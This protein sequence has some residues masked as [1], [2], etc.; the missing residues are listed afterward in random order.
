MVDRAG[1]RG[2]RS[3]FRADRNTRGG[4]QLS[5]EI[6]DLAQFQIPLF[7][8]RC[9]GIAERQ[10]PNT[11]DISQPFQNK[12]ALLCRQFQGQGVTHDCGQ[13]REGKVVEWA[14][15]FLEASR[16]TPPRA[17]VERFAIV[18]NHSADMLRFSEEFLN[19]P[20]SFSAACR[21]PTLPGRG[22][23]HSQISA[24]NSTPL[25]FDQP[26]S[27]ASQ[28]LVRPGQPPRPLQPK[29][30][31]PSPRSLPSPPPPQLDRRRQTDTISPP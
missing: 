20:A 8:G 5:H 25:P 14:E 22:W 19:R 30:H 13:D 3:R 15:S 11:A 7:I 6:A 16:G 12:V 31:L 9:H 18:T 27:R 21:N 26:P 17:V 24:R 2:D 28:I 4:I 1:C 10:P 23:I 29:R